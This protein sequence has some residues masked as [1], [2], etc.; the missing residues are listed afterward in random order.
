MCHSTFV[1][2]T[3]PFSTLVGAFFAFLCV[4][5]WGALDRLWLR[6]AQF[7]RVCSTTGYITSGLK[8]SS[9]GL[10]L[11]PDAWGAPNIILY[12]DIIVLRRA[13]NLIFLHLSAG[14]GNFISLMVRETGYLMLPCLVKWSNQGNGAA[15][16]P[17]PRCS[18]KREWNL[19]VTLDKSHQVFLLNLFL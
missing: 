3:S 8:P 1:I 2:S 9:E 4:L 11:S 16:S 10:G 14:H 13:C 19:W 18:S 12:P 15:P 7:V 5:W 6:A 17:T